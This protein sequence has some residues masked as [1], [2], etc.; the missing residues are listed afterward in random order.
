MPLDEFEE[1]GHKP[2]RVQIRPL[3]REDPDT[4]ELIGRAVDEDYSWP[5]IA[6]VTTDIWH[7]NETIPQSAVLD[8]MALR[9]AWYAV[10]G[11]NPKYPNRASNSG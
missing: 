1:R 8:P 5:S 11:R 9:E 3:L 4:T 7:E 2:K 6:A 10:T